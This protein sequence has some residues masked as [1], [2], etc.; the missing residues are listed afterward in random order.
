MIGVKIVGDRG[1][2]LEIS[3]VIGKLLA[4]TAKVMLGD[5]APDNVLEQVKSWGHRTGRDDPFLLAGNIANQVVALGWGV[6]VESQKVEFV[7]GAEE[8]LN[9][10]LMAVLPYSPIIINNSVY[11]CMLS[12][13]LPAGQLRQQS[14]QPVVPYIDPLT[15]NGY[16]R[17][18]NDMLSRLEFASPDRVQYVLDTLHP[19][20][21]QALN[22]AF[23][24]QRAI[25][26]VTRRVKPLIPGDTAQYQEHYK[27][28]HQEADK[29]QPGNPDGTIELAARL[30]ASAEAGPFVKLGVVYFGG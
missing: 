30:L 26:L 11:F 22:I 16:H 15:G 5:A 1:V 3:V 10:H 14:G 7:L 23:E 21:F 19:R 12:A 13:S 27:A 20:K 2:M 4:G 8:N 17:L 24:H 25:T 28:L 6:I 29:V 9:E 18:V